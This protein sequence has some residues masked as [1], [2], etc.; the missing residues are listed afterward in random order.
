MKKKL[1]EKVNELSILNTQLEL[2]VMRNH[3]AKE[4]IKKVEAE[5]ERL[6]QARRT[7]DRD[8][9]IGKLSHIYEK[10]LR[11]FD[12]EMKYTYFKIVHGQC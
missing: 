8:M 3:R 2:E 1:Y 12:G 10:M 7:V 11:L 6:K 4:A 9:D 5:M